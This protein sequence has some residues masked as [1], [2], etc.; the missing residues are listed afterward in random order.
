MK[1]TLTLI[2]FTLVSFTYVNAQ[3]TAGL[4]EEFKFN[5]T[6]NAEID[7][8]SSFALNAGTSLTTDRNNNAN[9]A[10]SLNNF[11]TSATINNLPYGKSAR[12]FSFWVKLDAYDVGGYNFVMEYGQRV[13]NKT[14]GVSVSANTTSYYGFA[15]DLDVADATPLNVW[16]HVVVTF[17]GKYAMVYSNG[18]LKGFADKNL[19]DTPN[20]N[21]SSLLYLGRTIGSL[22]T[23]RGA[24]DDLKIYNRAITQAEVTSL[25]TGNPIVTPPVVD[26]QEFKF[27]NSYA[28]EAG[29]ASF[30]ANAGTS[31]TTDRDGNAN[32]AVN[33]NNT[34]L[35]AVIPNLPYGSS[36]RTI[37]VWANLNNYI[38]GGFNYPFFY[39]QSANTFG[40]SVNS[41]TTVLY[42]DPTPKLVNDA[43]PLNTWNHY[44]ITFDGTNIRYY[45]NA[46]LISTTPKTLNTLNDADIFRL[47]LTSAGE[48]RFNGAIDDLK[49]YNRVVSDDEIK[50]IYGRELGLVEEWRF[51]NSVTNENGNYAFTGS[52]AQTNDR[53]NQ[54]AMARFIAAGSS[55]NSITTLPSANTS[56]TISA[57]FKVS[58]DGFRDLVCYGGT[59]VGAAFG[60]SSTYNNGSAVVN[61]YTENAAGVYTNAL[62]SAPRAIISS[63]DWYHVAIAYDGAGNAKMYYNGVLETSATIPALATPATAKL[64]VGQS[65]A[66]PLVTN[67]AIID[68]LKFYSRA[69]S[70]Q[71]V[72][73]LYTSNTSVLPL[74]TLPVSLISYTAKTQNGSAVLNWKTA[75]EFNNDYFLVER[76][77]DGINFVKLASIKEKSD[78]GAN[79]SFIDRNPLAN[80]NYY[81]LTQVDK[82]GTPTDYG[83]KALSF[84]FESDELAIYPNPVLDNVSIK[85]NAGTY[86]TIIVLNTNG[87]VLKTEKLSKVEQLK[88]L[89][90]ANYTTGVY[91][92]ILKGDELQTVKKIVK[93]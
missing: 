83:V 73:K 33:I 32:S 1:K 52:S 53:A 21:N 37:S 16:K 79:Y 75:S 24:I 15:N 60:L 86:H 65:I 17:D 38:A 28:S 42:S 35:A 82:D 67:F 91:V 11:G 39:G 8:A 6:L 36:N 71:E 87:S 77:A 19:W 55:V 69:L 58:Y 26:V 74:S 5:G 41:T 50:A 76:S 49:I 48:V 88:V 7:I 90:I 45:K 63:Q 14:N 23:F 10:L 29:N 31:F 70:A 68:D 25:Y 18:V 4:I 2:L 46:V 72:N 66:D 44:I 81:R 80:T 78:D 85:F 20:F 61:F 30:I 54:V 92:I 3:V 27:N 57:W 64:A 47:G 22:K 51:D 62:S 43:T 40:L 89:N 84:S 12:S 13:N 93:R 59:G 9:S 34:G 56:R